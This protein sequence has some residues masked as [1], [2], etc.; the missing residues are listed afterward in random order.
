M[1]PWGAEEKLERSWIQFT[2]QMLRT[3]WWWVTSDACLFLLTLMV[4][5]NETIVQED[6]RWILFHMNFTKQMR[7]AMLM[8]RTPRSKCSSHFEKAFL[9]E[10]KSRQ[11]NNYNEWCKFKRDVQQLAWNLVNLVTGCYWVTF[12]NF[13]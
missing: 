12:T 9:E 4:L 6:S 7:H 10:I 2:L 1:I 3:M 11:Q 8:H 5:L 13:L